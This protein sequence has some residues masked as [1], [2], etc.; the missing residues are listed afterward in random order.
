MISQVIEA[1]PEE[2]RVYLEEAAG[3]SKYKERRKETET[4]IRHTRENLDRLNDLREEVGKQLEHLKRQA[5]QAEQYTAIQAERRIKDA[6]WKALEFRGLDARL[7]GLREALSQEETRLQQLIAEQRE[8]ER[9]IETGRVR[10]EESAEALNRA[11]AAVYEVG[12]ALARIEQ[13]IAQVSDKVMVAFP[14]ALKGSEWTGNPVRGEIAAI[15]PPEKRFEGRSGPLRLLV[16]GGSLGAQALNEALPKALSLLSE[17]P[18]VVHQAGEK[19][20][21]TLR[22]NYAAAGVGGELVAFI[23]DM[24]RRYAEADVVVCRAGAI[25]V[26]ELSAGGVAS[27]LVPFPYAV[28]DHQTANA[29]DLEAAGAALVLP[30]A[31]ATPELLAEHIASLLSDEDRLARMAAAARALGRPDAHHQ[32][33][34]L[35]ASLAE[36]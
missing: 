15:A 10:R 27:I 6:E 21:E 25:T 17:R 9:E 30:Q 31:Q 35:L 33:A 20:I 2:L 7:Q 29:R 26:A 11:Q 1:K 24:A 32:I 36:A 3:I 18:I 8:A 14:D 12:G 16:V 4:R 28:D 5:R 34:D 19:H 23:D 13:Q 22:A